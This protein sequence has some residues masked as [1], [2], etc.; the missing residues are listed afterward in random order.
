[1]LPSRGRPPILRVFGKEVRRYRLAAGLS[2]D[3]LAEKVPMS[4]SH[5]GNIERGESRCE[6]HVAERFDEILDTKG[7]L[8]SLWD[9]LVKDV[10][11][12]VWFDWP[13]VEEEAV[14]LQTYQP[15]VVYGLL[16]TERYA[17]AVLEGDKQA[18][19]ARMSRQRILERTDPPPPRLSV[20]LAE[21]VLYNEV[22]GREIMREQLERLITLAS[23][24]IGVHIAQWPLHPLGF[25]GAF[26]IATLPDRSELAYV[27]T[28]ARGITTN[29]SADLRVLSDSYVAIRSGVLPV[30]A[31]IDLIRQVMEERWA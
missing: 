29:D 30:Q 5:V 31:S 6:R 20:I 15:M 4:G 26:V 8:P 25:S 3:R 7:A 12:P 9:E 27:E 14:L 13:P 17:T 22:G 2:Q 11:F 24:R 1:M 21:P 10:A 16:Q 18:V 23:P 19:D 28:P